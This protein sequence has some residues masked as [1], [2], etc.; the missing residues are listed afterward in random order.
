MVKKLIYMRFTGLSPVLYTHD[1]PGSVTFY[2]DVLG[3][4]VDSFIEGKGWAS[5]SRDDVTVM[6]SVPNEH[7]AFI[8]PTFT[9]S[10]Y[11]DVDDVDA[12]WEKVRNKA[13]ECYLIDNF[14]YG[15][16]EFAIYDNNGYL[17]RFGSEIPSTLS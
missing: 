17:L 2:R 16:R 3:F 8:G 1:I 11:I 6:F 10:F 13:R 5:V 14:N 15:M 7:V 12:M 4:V 9:G